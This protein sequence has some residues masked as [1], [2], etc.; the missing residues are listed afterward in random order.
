MNS[1]ITPEPHRKHHM[2][3]GI[4]HLL[5]AGTALLDHAVAATLAELV[6]AIAYLDMAMAFRSHTRPGFSEETLQPQ[7]SDDGT[8]E[9]HPE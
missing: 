2:F 8:A 3:C 5:L 1:M 6:I 4:A 9:R 7:V